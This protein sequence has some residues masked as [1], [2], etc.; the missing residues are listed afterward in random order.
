MRGYDI[1]NTIVVSSTGR[2]G[3]TWLAEMIV[4]IPKYHM[5]YEPFRPVPSQEK[6]RYGLTWNN[7]IRVGQDSSKRSEY[8]K[9]VLSGRELSTRTLSRREFQPLRLL[10]LQGLLVK[11]INAN[12]MLS[13]M[14]S[15][16][17][18]KG[19]LLVRHP[20]AVVAS[21]LLGGGW[22][23]ADRLKVAIPVEV[24]ED[25]PHLVPIYEDLS[26]PEENLAFEWAVETYVPFQ[27]NG[28]W[29]LTT[30][31]RLVSQGREELNRIFEY[32]GREVPDT[33][34][35]RIEQES[36]SGSSFDRKNNLLSDWKNRLDNEQIDKILGVVRRVGV[37][38]YNSELHPDY[39]KM[40]I[41]GDQ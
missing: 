28:S 1:G 16:F 3:S 5:V 23:W 30:Y 19:I 29:L 17:G 37:K 40:P 24:F 22:E 33:A 41:G 31:E 10:Q 25:Y 6:D 20:C 7:Y 18:V 32:L 26:S 2:S 12:M 34:I 36:A 4:S 8:V 13:W 14:C 15:Q 21:Q 27:Q 11:S 39:D 38:S 35:A 9:R